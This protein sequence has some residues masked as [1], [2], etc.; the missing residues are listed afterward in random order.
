MMT[1]KSNNTSNFEKKYP[2]YNLNRIKRNINNSQFSKF[3]FGNNYE[4]KTMDTISNEFNKY[5]MY[6]TILAI[7]SVILSFFIYYLLS[8][9]SLNQGNKLR[10]SIFQGY[11]SGGLKFHKDNKNKPK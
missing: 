6:V 5:F 4:F 9:I 2:N 10:S 1:T 3:K 7:I 11:V 8:S